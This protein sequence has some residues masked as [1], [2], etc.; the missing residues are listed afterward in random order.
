MNK[1]KTEEE[2]KL[3]WH[4][5]RDEVRFTV[6]KA[7]QKPPTCTARKVPEGQKGSTTYSRAG[8]ERTIDRLKGYVRSAPDAQQAQRY[9]K[10]LRAFVDQVNAAMQAKGLGPITEADG[11]P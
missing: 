6:R 10:A 3:P 5:Q 2:A 1:E 4:W 7:Y 11:S 9:L 8:L